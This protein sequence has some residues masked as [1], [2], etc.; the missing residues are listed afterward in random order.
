MKKAVLVDGDS[1]Q[2][3][4]PHDINY[5]RETLAAHGIELVVTQVNTDEEYIAACQDA[6]AV[7]IVFAN[8]NRNVIS[9]L[10]N[11]K[12][13][14]RYG[15]GYDVIDV[16]A[17]TDYNIAACNIPHYCSE[18]VAVHACALILDCVRRITIDDRNVKAGKWSEKASYA[19]SRLSNLVVGTLGFGNI[20]R[21][22][23][24]YMKAFGCRVMAYD[25]Y[26]PDTVFEQA[27]VQR[28]SKEDICRNADII[29]VHIPYNKETHHTLDQA[30]FAMMKDG[31]MI[32]NTARGGVINQ[33]ALCDALDSGKV[34]AAGLDVLEGEPVT[35]RN[36]RI[37]QY[38]N[39]TI[40]PHRGAQSTEATHDLIVQV[41]ETAITAIEGTLPEN[42]VNRKAL[43]EKKM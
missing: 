43:L 37:L 1:F 8:T 42:A 14:I 34:R 27:G 40:T 9:Q 29:S 10:K 7:L 36:A 22:V 23:A 16:D 15:V 20:A 12:A 6:D 39:V 38:S 17:A 21:K 31:V 26:L 19:Y 32:V 41:I 13:L 30:E 25:P 24:F 28:A 3:L 4:F 2:H 35:D 5:E 11:C 33:D 18:E